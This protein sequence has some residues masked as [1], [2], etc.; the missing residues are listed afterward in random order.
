[1]K[2]ISLIAVLALAAAI[3]LG[4]TNAS[5]GSSEKGSSAG[6]GSTTPVVNVGDNFYSRSSVSV[7]KNK[8]V[9]FVWVDTDNDHNVTTKSGPTSFHSKTEDGD[10]SYTKKFTTKGTYKL[11]CTIHPTK[12]K[13]TVKVK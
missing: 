9:K 8:K 6:S 2:R 5:K 7:K 13:V 11:H 3:T 10:F 1:M 4:C 12:M